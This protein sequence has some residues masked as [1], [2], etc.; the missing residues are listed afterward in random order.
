MNG[1]GSRG[2]VVVLRSAPPHAALRCAIA[3]ADGTHVQVSEYPARAG[4]WN[5]LLLSAPGKGNPTATTSSGVATPFI[6]AIAA[7]G[8]LALLVL[9]WRARRITARIPRAR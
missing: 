9:A 4:P 1:R 8:V 6:Y 2:A 3:N 5:P 7:L